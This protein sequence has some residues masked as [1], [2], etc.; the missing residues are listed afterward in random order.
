MLE[1]KRGGF[2]LIELMI[3]VCIISILAALAGIQYSKW[4]KRYCVEREIRQMQS[5]LMNAR[6]R[7]LMMNR[8]HFVT[9]ASNKYAVYEDTYD[10]SVHANTPD[11]D[12]ILQTT[13]PGDVAV[14]EKRTV[15]V[16][17]P[18]LGF[19][20]TTFHFDNRGLASL[21]GHIRLSSDVK[22][23]YDCIIL[24]TTRINIGKWDGSS[25]KAL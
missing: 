13:S 15:N 1:R 7:A 4:I 19:G 21:K 5:D 3:V 18:S 16:V 8:L 25:C 10:A 22:A 2:T 20:R 17:V 14:L 9:M 24:A 11:G 23:D 12:R 6:A